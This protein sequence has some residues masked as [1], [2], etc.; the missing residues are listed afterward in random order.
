MRCS[1]TRPGF[2]IT[3]LA[4]GCGADAFFLQVFQQA[5]QSIL[6]LAEAAV[7]LLDASPAPAFTGKIKGY[8]KRKRRPEAPLLAV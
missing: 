7:S 2:S 3:S 6:A 8:R 5:R 4:H 1:D